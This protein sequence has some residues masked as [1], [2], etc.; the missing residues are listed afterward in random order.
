MGSTRWYAWS[1]N[2]GSEL[3]KSSYADGGNHP[4]LFA[5]KSFMIC[6]KKNDGKEMPITTRKVI[7]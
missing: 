4:S 5:S 1:K 7:I 2:R 6:A 3:V